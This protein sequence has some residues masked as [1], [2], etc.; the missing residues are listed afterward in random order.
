L[1]VYGR[2]GAEEIPLQKRGL[3]P[4][5]ELEAIRDGLNQA[6]D[7]ADFEGSNDE[8]SHVT[9]ISCFNLK[10]EWVRSLA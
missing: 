9:Q 6:P 8:L 3:Y 2:E 1:E 4:V 7:A 5:K 10:V